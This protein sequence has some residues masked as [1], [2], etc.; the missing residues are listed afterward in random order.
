MIVLLRV[1]E[2]IK[3]L[4]TEPVTILRALESLS[5]R[6]E[7][8]PIEEVVKKTGLNPDDTIFHLGYL[9][10]EKLVQ[11]Q[12]K[13]Y[14]G[15]RLV[16]AGYDA[17]A[18]HALAAK[19]II[20]S[21]GQPLG[22]GKEATVYRALNGEGDEIALKFLRW[23]RTSFRQARRLRTLPTTLRKSWIDYCKKAAEK[24]F[25]A[26]QTLTFHK[27]QVPIPIAVNRHI[28][29]MSQMTGDLLVEVRDLENPQMV[30]R[31]ILDQIRIAFQDAKII[32]CDL[33]EYNIIIDEKDQITLFDWPQ[34][35]SIRHPN[36]HSLFRRDISYII[37]FFRRRFRLT[38]DSQETYHDI[39]HGN[40]R[41]T[42][43]E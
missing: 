1:A 28:L 27:V 6:F 24:E 14:R 5:K 10:K 33:S 35:V 19:D 21:I 25:A 29:V 36:A 17:L 20:V 7:Y 38:V 32:H 15:Y 41:C 16:L 37:N 43:S 26:L 13:P 42:K 3:E 9:N 30:L 18:L 40:G 2:L 22:T 34:W 4:G 8:I 39:V 11:R 31:Q 12:T 23:G